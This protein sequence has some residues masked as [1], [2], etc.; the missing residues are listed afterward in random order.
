[1]RFTTTIKTL[2]AAIAAG[3]CMA[4]AAHAADTEEVK[5]GYAGPLTGP[6]AHYGEDM[7]N[8]LTLAIEEANKKGIK[9]DGKT[10]KFVLVSK[11]DQADPK[12]G[13]TVAQQL[14]DE[15]VK[16][17]LGH[18]NSG[19][20]IPASQVYHDAGVPQIAMATAPEYT[21]QGYDSAF[22]M[23]TSDTQQG[24]AVGEFMV[25]DLKAKKV[26]IID[27]RTAYGQGLADQVEKA[28][29]ANG[30]QVVRREY[31]TD[32][33]NDFTA[34]LTNIK[35]SAPDAIFY[36]GLDAQSGPMKRQLATLGIK[37]P[38]VSGEMTR[39]ETFLKLAGDA[40]DGT[41]ASL[42]GVPLDKM[43]AGKEFEQAYKARFKSE[44]GVYA[45]YAYDGAWNM[46]TAMEQA[47]SADPEKY[48]PMLRKLDRKGATSEHIAYDKNGDLKEV[49]VTMYQVKD[50]KWQMVK[51]MVSEAK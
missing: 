15:D 26:A 35:G 20:T 12:T 42:A 19:T 24:T 11:D 21:K 1:M 47:K 40:A 10:A 13:V 17:I 23:M 28:V 39:S 16:G 5:L 38:F 27:D 43:A 29:K 31:T 6:Q 48:L 4:G 51:T 49:S 37:V 8:G 50:G 14:V 46:I 45:P 41:Y 9:L 34:I 36:G 32:K 2:A 18:F 33:A 7:Q 3:F 22:R 25:K 44:P 30:G